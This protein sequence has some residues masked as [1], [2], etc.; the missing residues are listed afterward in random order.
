MNVNETL[1]FFLN[2]QSFMSFLDNHQLRINVTNLQYNG[3]L[4][5]TI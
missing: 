4:K 1:L 2:T 5:I 3:I